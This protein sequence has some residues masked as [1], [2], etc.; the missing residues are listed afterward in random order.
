MD[1]SKEPD[2]ECEHTPQNPNEVITSY[3]LENVPEFRK[4]SELR[5]KVSRLPSHT[6]SYCI[7]E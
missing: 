1:A 5:E 7:T 3:L 4:L 6:V 2:P